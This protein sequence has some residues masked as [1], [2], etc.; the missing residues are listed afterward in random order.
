MLESYILDTLLVEPSR[1]VELTTPTISQQIR[2]K[3]I[4]A[5]YLGLEEKGMSDPL[6]SVALKYR[7]SL[8]E[9]LYDAVETIISSLVSI[10]IVLLL[11]AIRDFATEQ[12]CSGNW[13]GSAC[14]KEYLL[15]PA[16]ELEEHAWYS[17]VFPEMI[18]LRHTHALY[19]KLRSMKI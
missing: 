3:H 10:E 11:T 15:Y 18:E 1:W 17:S 8:E 14:L 12:L 6:E 7:D 4:Q 16:P 19:H 13:S 5:L 2:I 9:P